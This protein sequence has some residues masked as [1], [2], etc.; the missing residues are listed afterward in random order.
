METLEKKKDKDEGSSGDSGSDGFDDW[1]GQFD[2]WG[3][4][5]EDPGFHDGKGSPFGEG[6][7][8]GGGEYNEKDKYDEAVVGHIDEECD[9]Y[10]AVAASPCGN[11]LACAVKRSAL[12]GDLLLMMDA[13]HACNPQPHPDPLLR[14][15]LKPID[16]NASL[17]RPLGA[18]IEQWM[19]D[20]GLLEKPRLGAAPGRVLHAGHS[21]AIEIVDLRDG[22]IRTIVPDPGS[23]GIVVE[24][25]DLAWSPNSG[26]LALLERRCGY[27]GGSEEREGCVTETVHVSVWSTRT[28]E[29]IVTINAMVHEGTGIEKLIWSRW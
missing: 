13:M 20:D 28:L 23:D 19:L 15:I 5:F 17:P 14:K 10:T 27:T 16:S 1:E 2:G 29:G 11:F 9:R 26:Y 25:P 24:I 18:D 7:D 4:E 8:T 3:D 21:V 6:F 22:S 12:R